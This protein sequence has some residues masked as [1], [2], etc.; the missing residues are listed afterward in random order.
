M[1]HRYSEAQPSFCII[2]GREM[3]HRYSEAQTCKPKEAATK[4]S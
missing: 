4:D 3:L 2:I 1:L